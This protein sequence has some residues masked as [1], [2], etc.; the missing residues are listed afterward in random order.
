MKKFFFVIVFLVISGCYDFNKANDDINDVYKE[1]KV[2]VK[3][4]CNL[5]LVN[6]NPK[7]NLNE[8]YYVSNGYMCS[9]GRVYFILEIFSQDT[10]PVFSK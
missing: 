10:V 1:Y 6:I 9:D 5:Y 4:N 8:N 3:E 7:P 2:K